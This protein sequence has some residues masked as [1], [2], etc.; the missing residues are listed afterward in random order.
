MTR[1]LGYSLRSCLGGRLVAC[2][3]VLALTACAA[4]NAPVTGSEQ[5]LSAGGHTL[6]DPGDSTDQTSEGASPALDFQHYIPFGDSFVS[7]VGATW[8]DWDH[9][10]TSPAAWPYVLQQRLDIPDI[11]FA[12]CSA[13]TTEDVVGTGRLG[14]PAQISQLPSPEELDSSLITIAIGGNDLRLDERLQTCLNSGSSLGSLTSGC[15]DLEQLLDTASEVAPEVLA[16]K[17][18][19]TFHTLREAAPNATI[20][21]VG[22]PHLVDASSDCDTTLTGALIS[23]A[24][25]KRLNLV[26][27]AINTEI[28]K[29]AE[30]AGMLWATDDVVAAFAG[31][32]ACSKDEW[33]VSPD[34]ALRTGN[35]GLSHP[36]DR[37]QEAYA[38]GVLNALERMKP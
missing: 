6:Y 33:I 11:I 20:V 13:A 18:A 4:E 31:H 21:A 23:R 1:T 32:E 38:Q 14:M 29:A 19:S 22:Y 3:S 26:A 15:S 36:N 7:G 5:G 28:S 8:V 35:I 9:C 34:G 27:D 10:G 2:A 30:N 16:P 25:R 37:G 17:L 12:A 24:N